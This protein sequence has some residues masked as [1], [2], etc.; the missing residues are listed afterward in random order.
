MF[1]WASCPRHYIYFI[2]FFIMNHFTLQFYN[3]NYMFVVFYD[4][5]TK[6]ISATIYKFRVLHLPSAK[7]KISEMGPEASQLAYPSRGNVNCTA[8]LYISGIFYLAY[9]SDNLLG[10]VAVFY[11]IKTKWDKYPGWY[12]GAND[13]MNER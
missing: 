11:I 9:W 5:L 12:I 7:Q 4:Y 2:Y 8:L 1:L 13:G 10:I 3:Y 6:S